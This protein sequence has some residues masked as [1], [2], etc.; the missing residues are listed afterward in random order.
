MATRRKAAANPTP[1]GAD[2]AMPVQMPVAIPNDPIEEDEFTVIDRLRAMSGD[3]RDRMRIKV[4]RKT[5]QGALEW[6]S[7]YTISEWEEGGVPRVRADWGSGTYEMRCMI[8]GKTG[9]RYREVFR[10]AAENKPAAPPAPAPA[11][12]SELAD[13]VRMLAEGQQR[14][15]EAVSQRPDPTAQLQGTLALMASMREAMGLNAPPPPP[16]PAA[17][18]G[19]M[20]GQLVGAIRQLREVATEVAPPAADP[21]N[22]MAMLGQIAEVVK[23][24]MAQQQ[25]TM[26]PVQLPASIAQAPQ[27]QDDGDGEMFGLLVLRGQLQTLVEMAKGGASHEAGADFVAEN[28]PDDLLGYL[29]LPNILEILAKANPAVRDHEAW[30]LAVRDRAVQL[31]QAEDDSP[32]LP[33]K[34]AI[35]R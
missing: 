21:D 19:A 22:P 31:L 6:C 33:P 23:L 35:N 10:I 15:L 14:I 24:G 30:F 2:E 7:D 26:P 3:D 29:P 5:I 8:M 1:D 16:P 20:L 25:Q 4:Y 11:P 34:D 13:V 12:P 27:P 18:P 9:V 17:D 28:L 32:A